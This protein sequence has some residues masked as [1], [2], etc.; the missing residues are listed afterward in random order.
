MKPLENIRVLD[1]TRLLPGAVCTMMLFDMGA[2]IIKIEDPK[3]GDYARWMPPMID[4]LGAFFRSSN[5]GKK[6]VIIDL[7]TEDGQAVLHRLA[8]SADVVIEGFRPD[9][10][11]RL[12]A[13]YDTLKA[14]N[15]RIVY[16]SLS[17]WGQTGPYAD[18][19]GH[20]LNYMALN[21]FLG[22][23]ETPQPLGGQVA[24]VGGSYVGVMGILAALLK[25]STT[26]KGDYID[27][28]LSE[29]AMPLAMVSWV[30]SYISK[31]DRGNLS[32]TGANAYYRVYDAKDNVPMALGAIEA[33]FWANFCTAIGRTEW[34]DNY[35]DP[36]RQPYLIQS[37]TEMF[38]TRTANEWGKL[39]G[40]AD[41]CFTRITSPHELL[42]DSHIQVRGMVGVTEDGVPWM[43]SPIRLTEDDTID[44]SPAPD[45]GADTDVILK[46]LG[47][48]KS[49]LEQLA[50][51][52]II[53]QH[54][55][56]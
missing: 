31:Q 55:N 17:G 45:Y 2:E 32:L 13:D 25:R 3:A 12:K 11:K 22:A 20:D 10:T 40:E 53:R 9:V 8:E 19:S 16:C 5:R 37:L 43:R 49:E 36:S 46:D 34:I 44:L 51:S 48:T 28:A 7:K 27:V 24:D 50:Q 30:E 26:G 23:Q 54:Q 21:G 47:Y 29:S 52:N 33:K 18:V 4:G 14:I 1:L 35:T 15:P 39:L 41:C 42:D 38:K 6:S 56:D